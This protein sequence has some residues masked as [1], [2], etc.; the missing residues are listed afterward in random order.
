M[1]RQRIPKFHHLL[2]AVL[3]V[4][5]MLT[6]QCAWA[7]EQL[8]VNNYT[9]STGAD[10]EGEYYVI[11]GTTALNALAT[12]V[13]AGN[14]ASGK[15]FKMTASV[16]YSYAD[17]YAWNSDSETYNTIDNNN[18]TPIGNT[19]N[20]FSGIFDG[21]GKTVSGIRIFRDGSADEAQCFGLFGYVGVGGKVKNVTIADVRITGHDNVGGIAGKN[22]GIVANSHVASNVA[23]HAVNTSAINHGGIVGYNMSSG[24]EVSEVSYCTSAA[25]LSIKAGVTNTN[26]YGG[27][28]GA[29]YGA[30]RY[31]IADGAIVPETAGVQGA[32]AGVNIAPGSFYYNYYSNCTVGTSPSDVG[33]GSGDVAVN[34]GAV[35]ATVLH[36]N[37]PV[38]S[39][40]TG[41]VAFR[42][43]FTGGI[44]ST[45][46]FPFGYTKGSEGTYYTFTGVSYTTGRWEATMT[47]VEGS[48]LT[49]NTPY[50]FKPAGT[51]SHQAVLFHG[52]AAYAAAG[53]TARDNWTFKGVYEPKTWTAGEIGN[54]YGFAATSGKGTDGVTNVAAGEFVQIG[55]GAHINSLRSYLTYT[56]GGNPWAAPARRDA[57]QELP[58]TI[59]VVLRAANGQTTLIDRLPDTQSG[60]SGEWYS[61]G[62]VRLNGM[63]TVPGIYIFNG[64]KVVIK[65]GKEV[66]K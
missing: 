48:T 11:D 1:I 2:V 44:P 5:A 10:G 3:V 66:L 32:I 17:G 29:N 20:G 53:A 58:Q 49:A 38:S 55:A 61:L 45:V 19:T 40:L 42:R 52:T 59:T 31:N 18:Y 54:D 56:G 50:L 41:K 12:Y 60:K 13:N 6:G 63:P 37:T 39:S 21:D 65:S 57:P 33:T 25:Q 24:S 15:R 22:Q 8:K 27:I 35:A 16:T 7:L 28:V 26:Y 51:A 64:E 4:A 47:E 34:D 36:E 46:V 62:G 43:E 30:I 14:N 23:I 9:F